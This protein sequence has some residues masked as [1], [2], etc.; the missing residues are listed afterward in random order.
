MNGVLA[1]NKPTGITSFDCIRH[2]RKAL[3]I[4]KIGHAGTLDPLATGVLIVLLGDATKLSNY[5]MSEVKTYEFD[6]LF[7]VATDTEDI[8]GKVLLDE[9]VNDL[10]N[11]KI[12]EMLSNLT[13]VI[14]QI[15]PM[16]SAIKVNGKKLYEYARSGIEIERKAREVEVFEIKRISDVEVCDNHQTVKLRATVSKGTYIRTLATQIGERLSHLATITSLNRIQSGNICLDDCYSLED[17]SSGNYKLIDMVTATKKYKQIEAN[18]YLKNKVLHGMKISFKDIDCS[19][20]LIFFTSNNS[21]IGIYSRSEV[22]Y[23]A[24][25]VW[26]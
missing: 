19:D 9:D 8:M 10:T 25:R 6:C 22:C 14:E 3:H 12:D 2:V 18:D 24:E 5:L 17:I 1:I 15:P 26:N 16:Y 21:L 7:G 20:E 4:D 11:E 13:G 23:K